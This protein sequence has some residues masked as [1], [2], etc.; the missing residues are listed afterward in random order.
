MISSLSWQHIKENLTDVYIILLVMQPVQCFFNK[1]DVLKY[2]IPLST[3]SPE[4]K[5]DNNDLTDSPVIFPA[6][7]H[8]AV[9]RSLTVI[10]NPGV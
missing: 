2:L 3:G 5:K 4:R 1:Q 9:F 8:T 10:L 6:N 7:S